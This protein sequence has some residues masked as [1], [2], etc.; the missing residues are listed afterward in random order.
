MLS[1]RANIFCLQ[2]RDVPKQVN[3]HTKFGETMDLSFRA[4]AS[5]N[6]IWSP[7]GPLTRN[8]PL[9]LASDVAQK[10]YTGD[11]PKLSGPQSKRPKFTAIAIN[12]FSLQ[13]AI[14][15][16]C[17]APSN[18]KPVRAH[19]A[20]FIACKLTSK[21]PFRRLCIILFRTADRS[22][23]NAG[24]SPDARKLRVHIAPREIILRILCDVPRCRF[25]QRR[26]CVSLCFVRFR[27]AVGGVC[28][29]NFMRF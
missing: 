15:S 12:Q 6:Y 19:L 22:L 11:C 17:C 7:R 29:V 4:D 20:L 8:G 27:S 5:S 1:P 16:V 9:V 25:I 26:N 23:F 2:Y 24:D 13:S 21:S 10:V 3:K 14:K 28:V 18:I